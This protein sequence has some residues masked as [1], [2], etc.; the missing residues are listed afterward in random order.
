MQE[1]RAYLNSFSPIQDK[2]W[3]A[4]LECF[5]RS[6]LK[7]GEFFIREG[8]IA[9]SFGFLKSGV[10]RAFYRSSSMMEY[11]KRFFTVP[12]IVGSYSSLI[13]GKPS[14]F[15]QQALLDCELMTAEYQSMV[16]L[17]DSFPDLE[18]LGRRFAE[19]FFVRNE[20]KEIEMALQ[21]AD[22]RYENFHIEHPGLEQLI[23]QYHIASYLGIS[24]T[25]LSRVRKKRTH[26]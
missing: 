14:L 8:E 11:N 5:T 24:P 16:K 2:A 17:Y 13:T 26:R 1:L 21:N 23:A 18:R 20:Q 22:T 19:N 6:S 7:K 12:S 4:L 15:S 9:K 3:E 10:V 25:Q